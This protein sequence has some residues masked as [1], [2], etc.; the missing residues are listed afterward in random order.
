MTGASTAST[1]TTNTDILVPA[2]SVVAASDPP[3]DAES[4]HITFLR[5]LAALHN[6]LTLLL[7]PAE[8]TPTTFTTNDDRDHTD[9]ITAERNTLATSHNGKHHDESGLAH[10]P[11]DT[12]DSDDHANATSNHADRHTADRGNDEHHY[13]DPK[14]N[15]QEHVAREPNTSDNDGCTQ[16]LT[17]VPQPWHR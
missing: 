7:S 12:R 1:K 11:N 15:I 6:E 2:G 3:A 10:H 13:D 17:P 14:I 5:E 9:Q 8:K 4:E 16:L